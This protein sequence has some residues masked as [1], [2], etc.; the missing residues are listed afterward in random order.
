MQDHYENLYA[1]V[2]GEK[3]FTLRPPSSLP[4]MHM[5]TYAVWKQ[6][7]CSDGSFTHAPVQDSAGGAQA[8]KVR[9]CAVDV[10][11]LEHGGAAARAEQQ[12]RFPRYFQG[13]PPLRVT[14]RAGDLLYLPAMWFHYVQQREGSA[15]A[16][17]A[18]NVWADMRFDARYAHHELLERLCESVGLAEAL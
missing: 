1:V 18:V 10:D 9:W 11:A 17:I 8:C 3:T 5:R 2:A 15:E 13:P 16:V 12:A 14:V 6:R 7:L 4:H